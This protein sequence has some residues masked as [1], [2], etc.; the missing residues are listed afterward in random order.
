MD[1]IELENEVSKIKSKMPVEE[2][3]QPTKID[4][5]SN[6]KTS[7][8]LFNLNEAFEDKDDTI[9]TD[10]K[11][12]AKEQKRKFV[13]GPDKN[14]DRALEKGKLA[15]GDDYSRLKDLRRASIICPNIKAII[16]LLLALIAAGVDICR[17]SL[18]P[19]TMV[20]L[21]CRLPRTKYSNFRR[22]PIFSDQEP[23]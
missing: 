7:D 9:F 3:R 10:V 2:P 19:H 20:G 18:C 17:V 13:K 6:T 15:Y 23:V 21:A 8:Y 4:G 22:T 12:V 14:D 5:E 11:A 1:L 16:L